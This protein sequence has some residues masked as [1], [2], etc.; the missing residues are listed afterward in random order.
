MDL[1]NAYAAAQG[2]F[3]DFPNGVVD[4]ETLKQNGFAPSDGVRLFI[5]SGEKESLSMKS[6]HPDGCGRVYYID[7]NGHIEFRETE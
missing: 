4:L 5:L 2:Y 6:Y 7:S 3:T 1:K